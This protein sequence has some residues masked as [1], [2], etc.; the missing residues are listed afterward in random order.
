MV[1]STNQ[2]T[3]QFFVSAP[4][5]DGEA[6]PLSDHVQYESCENALVK[7]MRFV[8]RQIIREELDAILDP[9][10]D[11]G[12]LQPKIYGGLLRLIGQLMRL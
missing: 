8:D 5:M 9:L 12:I 2:K 3:W 10:V 11:A 4:N 7:A 6:E 1:L